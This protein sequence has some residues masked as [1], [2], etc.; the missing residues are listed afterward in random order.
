MKLNKTILLTAA[1]L[2]GGLAKAQQIPLYSNY[3]F[4][5]YIYNPSMSGTE[6]ST[7]LSLI[8]R[9]QWTGIQGSPETSAFAVDGSLNEEKVGWS[10]YGFS[11]KTDI[12]NRLGIYGNYAYHLQLSDNTQLSFGLGAGYLNNAIDVNNI[13]AQQEGDIFTITNGNRGTF[14]IN[15]GLSLKIADFTLGGAAPQIIGQSIKY[16]E[17][18]NREVAYSLLRHYVVNAQYD[19]K[20]DGDRRVLSPMVM[21]RAAKNVPIQVDAGVMFQ[22]EEYGHI[23]AMYR[24]D[25]A[26]TGNIGIN[27]TEQLTVGYAYDFSL[28]KYSSSLG[29]SHEFMLSYKFGSDKRN[30]RLENEIKRLKERQRRAQD[31]TEEMV[32]EK[33]EEF[34]DE[35]K[36]ELKEEM[37]KAAD[38]AAQEAAKQAAQQTQDAN[39]NNSGQTGGNT[40]QDNSGGNNNQ[41]G[42]NQGQPVDNSGQSGTPVNRGGAVDNGQLPSQ[43]SAGAP[44]YYL[45]AGVFSNKA[46]ADR[47]LR[48]LSQEGIEAGVFQD[49]GNY[50]Y[51]V[52]IRRYNSYQAADN[53]KAS[54]MNGRYN[55]ELWIKVVK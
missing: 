9:R 16:A 46:N 3:F 6:G 13:R 43:I 24:S 30:E 34:K 18:P 15:A 50:F 22:L 4:T 49:P 29:S 39:R 19:F 33:L 10:V 42:Q 20:F 21:V 48:Q 28:N 17:T 11:D 54:N 51:Y 36:R 44:G 40:G 55:G 27:L 31:Q 25:Y 7:K 5:P 1:L 14:D 26:V 32:D 2:L 12:L 38:D 8:H 52:F 37:K 45:I 35:Y 41:A 23:G 53:A 47:R